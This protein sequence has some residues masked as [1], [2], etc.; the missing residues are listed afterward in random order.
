MVRPEPGSVCIF[1]PRYNT[2]GKRDATGAFQPGAV[3]FCRY[4]G[5]DPSAIH[6]V[7]N[8]RG[9]R[10]RSKEV[11]QVLAEA[12]PQVAVFF[13]HGWATGIQLGLRSREHRLFDPTAWKLFV[14][15]LAAHEDPVVVLYCCSTGAD[16]DDDPISAPGYGDNSFGGLLRTSLVEAGAKGCR[17]FTHRTAGH[18]FYNPDIVFYEGGEPQAQLVVPPYGRRRRRLYRLLKATKLPWKIPFM[19]LPSIQKMLGAT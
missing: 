4:W 13:C 9:F 6:R 15:Y 7:N 2:R 17:V 1:V 16:P 11:L 5:I 19:P 10:S 14:S 12:K 18:S 8:R 3:K